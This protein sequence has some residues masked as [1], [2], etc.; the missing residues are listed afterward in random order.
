MHPSYCCEDCGIFHFHWCIQQKGRICTLGSPDRHD[1]KHPEVFEDLDALRCTTI[2][3]V[4][5]HRCEGILGHTT[6]CEDFDW[7]KYESSR[8]IL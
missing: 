1:L 5:G 6:V 8:E 2:F 7:P 3:K 4:S